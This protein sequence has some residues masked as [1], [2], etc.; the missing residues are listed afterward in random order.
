[1]LARVEHP[2][3]CHGTFIMT[4]VTTTIRGFCHVTRESLQCLGDGVLEQQNG[5][6]TAYDSMLAANNI[7]GGGT[8]LVSVLRL[9]ERRNGLWLIVWIHAC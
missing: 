2:L 9:V 3:L 4:M 7:Q 5:C 1:M 6:L 8:Q